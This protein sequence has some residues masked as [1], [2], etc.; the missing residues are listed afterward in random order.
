MKGEGRVE[1]EETGVVLPRVSLQ[2]TSEESDSVPFSVTGRDGTLCV[3]EVL[4]V[5]EVDGGG[6]ETGAGRRERDR[7][8][9]STTKGGLTSHRLS[10]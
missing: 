9:D 8:K 2:Y 7:P 6:R 1:G 3:S 5:P 4:S 10:L